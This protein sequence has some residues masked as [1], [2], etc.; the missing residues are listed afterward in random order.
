MLH[1]GVYLAA[2]AGDLR[3]YLCCQGVGAYVRRHVHGNLRVPLLAVLHG[4]VDLRKHLASASR[5]FPSIAASCVCTY[6]PGPIFG[7]R[8]QPP[9]PSLLLQSITDHHD[10]VALQPRVP[11]GLPHLP[12]A[13]RGA[14]APHRLPC[15]SANSVGAGAGFPAAAAG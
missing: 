1:N 14:A 12:I 2:T 5:T 6:L 7:P 8:P 11:Q 15:L 13:A 10:V 4:V 9:T 3:H